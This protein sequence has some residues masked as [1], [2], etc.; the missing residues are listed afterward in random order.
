[1]KDLAD[2]QE[3]IKTLSLPRAV[4]GQLNGEVV[5]KFLELWDAVAAAPTED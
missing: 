3:L 5:P 4:A 2:V 1:M